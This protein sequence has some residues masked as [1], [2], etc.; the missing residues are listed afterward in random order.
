[1]TP[2]P[3]AR[4][5]SGFLAPMAL[6]FCSLFL[7]AGCASSR[8]ARLSGSFPAEE[9]PRLANAMTNE[10]AVL[11]KFPKWNP[12]WWFRNVD[13]VTPPDWYRPDDPNRN[14]RFQLR[15]P[16]HNFTFYV[17]GVADKRFVRTGKHP[18]DVFNPNGGWNW[19][20]S[21]YKWARLPFV[22]FQ[23]QRAKF[24]F[25]WR[26]RGNFGIK[27]TFS[28]PDEPAIVSGEP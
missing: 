28:R 5:L 22:S 18:R 3:A 15:N 6:L 26:E 27:L 11:V 14:T 9:N 1:M 13:D 21:R 8:P 4:W 24:Y 23:G 10:P 25:G 20:V 2:L 16:A 19:A 12:V 7:A 17:I